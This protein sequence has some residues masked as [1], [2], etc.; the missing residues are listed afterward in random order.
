[1]SSNFFDFTV[2]KPPGNPPIVEVKVLL[3]SLACVV[4]EGVGAAESTF[5]EV[6]GAPGL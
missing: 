6:C 2:F 3:G 1:M 4:P 5:D